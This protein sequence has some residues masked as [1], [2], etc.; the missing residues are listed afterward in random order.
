MVSGQYVPTSISIPQIP[1]L[2]SVTNI[3]GKEFPHLQIYRSTCSANNDMSELEKINSQ[4]HIS[5]FITK[6][7]DLKIGSSTKQP[8]VL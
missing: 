6:M 5:L 1:Y 3:K 8:S 2:S 4:Y 7:V